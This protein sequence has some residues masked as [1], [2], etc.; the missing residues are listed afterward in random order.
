[1]QKARQ[2]G[3]A[4]EVI[5]VSV[6]SFGNDPIALAL[7]VGATVAVAL[8]QAGIVRGSQ[9]IFCSGEVATDSDMLEAGDVLSIVSP[10][11]AGS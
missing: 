6:V 10:K 1:M 2:S 9:E 3:Q 7:P 11:Q 8:A 4:G 5:A